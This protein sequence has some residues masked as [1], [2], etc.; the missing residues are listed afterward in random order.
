LPLAAY[1][2]ASGTRLRLRGLV[3]K[4]DGTQVVRAEASGPVSA[5]EELGQK[6]AAELRAQGADAILASL[7]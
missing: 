3:A 5:P 1:A 6:L 2:E 4:P 7:A